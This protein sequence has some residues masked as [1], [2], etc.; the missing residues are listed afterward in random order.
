MSINNVVPYIAFQV[1]KSSD[2]RVL[3]IADQ[4]VYAHLEGGPVYLDILLPG[5]T[6]SVEVEFL[7]HQLN[8][9]NANNLGLSDA[10]SS[11]DLPNLPDGIYSITVR[12]CPFESF[13]ITKTHLQNC[14]QLCDFKNRLISLDL[15]ACCSDKNDRTRGILS[16]ISLLIEASEAHAARCN[17][18]GAMDCYKKAD[19]LLCRLTDLCIN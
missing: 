15:L 6:T 13:T 11:D 9:I 5:Y 3:M 12:M 17:I 10:N 16:D 14:Q 8:I 7:P 19:E 4:S 18:K 2:C 1:L